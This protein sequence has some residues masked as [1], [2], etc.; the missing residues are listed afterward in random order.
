MRKEV[1]LCELLPLMEE[2]I[3]DGGTFRFYPRGISM[4]PLI[5][6]GRD[7]VELGRADDIALGDAVFYRRDNGQYVL[8][9]IVDVRNGLYTMCGDHQGH[10][11][12]YGIRREQVL[13][14]LVGYYKGEEY[15]SADE[16]AYREYVKK[17]LASIPF[18]YKIPWVRAFLRKIK[19]IFK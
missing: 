19:R 11:L 9:R 12:E 10:A 8:H 15:H 1:E 14:K 16:E 5:C 7:S 13:Y 18:Y 3:A 6:Q 17:R 4:Q 2:V